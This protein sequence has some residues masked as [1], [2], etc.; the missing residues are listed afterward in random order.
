M[1]MNTVF[2]CSAQLLVFAALLAAGPIRADEPQASA[3]AQARGRVLNGHTFMPAEDV[4]GA[5]VTTSVVSGFIAGI[6][7]TTGTWQ[8][9]DQTLSGNFEYAAIGAALGYEYAFTDNFSARVGF[10]ESIYSGITG[11]SAIVVGTALTAGGG[12]GLTY[13]LPLLDA[14]RAGLRFDATYTPNMALTIGSAIKDVVDSCSQPSGCDV[15]AGSA[16]Q[17]KMVLELKPALAANWAVTPG[18]GVTANAAYSYYSTTLNG[19][20]ST[21]DALQLGV[22]LDYDFRPALQVP[23]GLQGQFSWLAP[24]GSTLQHITDL[25]G[26]LFYTGKPDL[27]LGIQLISRRFAVTP[28]VNVS[29]STLLM[30][31]S[32][33]YYW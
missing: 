17:Q 22:A 6:G 12:A 28:D 18:L 19:K 3:T 16:F 30:N 31:I 7:T 11:K 2:R 9:Q 10:A 1:T 21:A 32:M 4:Q 26:G 14:L 29:W 24:G 33:R 13:S 15:N 25:G 20:E 5:L 23:V 8:V 27:S